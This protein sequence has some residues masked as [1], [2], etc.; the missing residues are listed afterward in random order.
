MPS[1]NLMERVHELVTERGSKWSE[2]TIVLETEGY[3]EG[4]QPLNSNTIRKRYAR[5]SKTT[6]Q[7]EQFTETMNKPVKELPPPV[8]MEP[9]SIPHEETKRDMTL[10]DREMF[11]LL[12]ESMERRDQMLSRQLANKTDKE[13]DA[14]RDERL[15]AHL[16]ARMEARVP[17]V[18][19]EQLGQCRGKAAHLGRVSRPL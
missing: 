3:Q 14:M 4:G 17:E 7:P 15:E 6:T 5:W 10:S 11:D 12:R 18:V 9:P 1:L 2:I 13:Y 8:P 19:E 16:T